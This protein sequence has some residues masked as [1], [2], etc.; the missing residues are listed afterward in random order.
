MSYI[1]KPLHHESFEYGALPMHGT[2]PADTITVHALTANKRPVGFA[3]WQ[4][5]KKRKKRKK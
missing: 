1:P 2:H 4:K 5:Q 3:P